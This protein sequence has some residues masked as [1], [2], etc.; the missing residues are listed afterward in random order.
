MME[1]IEAN[2]PLLVLALLVGLAIAWWLFVGTRRTTVTRDEDTGEA[3]DTGAKRNQ[4]LIDAPAAAASEIAQDSAHGEEMAEVSP[5]PTSA[6]ANS[7]ATA[8]AGEQADAEAGAPGSAREALQEMRDAPPPP[9]EAAPSGDGDD[10]TRIKG[11]GP[12]LK[13]TLAELGVTRFDQ[14]AGWSEADIDRVDAQL[15]RFQGRIRR[16]DWVEQARL[17]GSGDEA[18]YEGKFGKL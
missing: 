11:L 17:L 10:L 13:A 12:K 3:G 5:G 7:N 4:A 1:L 8:H 16:D 15:G 2:W 9:A 6:A 18:G 14:I